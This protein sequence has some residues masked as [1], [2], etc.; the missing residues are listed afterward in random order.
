[1]A[2]ISYKD[3]IQNI[4]NTRG[5]FNIPDNVYKERH[6]IIPRCIGGND[7]ID[8]LID[9]FAREHFIAHKLLAKENMNNRHLVNAWT[10]MAFAVT[11]TQHR[12]ELTPEEY[13][14]AKVAVAKVLSEIAKERVYD[15]NPKAKAVVNITTGET[16]NTIKEAAEK[17]RCTY[18]T[19]ISAIKKL[20]TAKGCCWMYKKEFDQLTPKEINERLNYIEE[21]LEKSSQARFSPKAIAKKGMAVKGANNG[22][23]RRIMCL[24][25]GETYGSIKDLAI[26]H[27]VPYDT[28]QQR[29]K[30]YRNNKKLVLSCCKHWIYEDD[31]KELSSDDVTILL[32]KALY[33]E[34]GDPR[35][36]GIICVETGEIVKGYSILAK[37][38][39]LKNGTVKGRF[40]TNNYMFAKVGESFWVPED[41]YSQLTVNE[42]NDC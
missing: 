20:G 29:F 10:M 24:E 16:F 4:L 37:K 1:M 21:K 19:I 40:Q 36:R 7:E 26:S 9:L 6:H 30:N 41:I 5:R 11:D 31:Y 8:N 12:Y 14:E 23:A 13:Q 3:Y 39:G 22:S 35:A 34:S 27:K 15:D 2:E 42:I 32:N 38:Y 17:Y 33:E 18:S 25:T 28:M